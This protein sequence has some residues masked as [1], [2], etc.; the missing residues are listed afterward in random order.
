MKEDSLEKSASIRNL[1]SNG[2]KKWKVEKALKSLEDGKVTFFK[3]AEIAGMTVWDFADT[4]K[5]IATIINAI[6]L[7][8]KSRKLKLL[9][10]Y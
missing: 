1:L 10:G 6:S 3:A 4:N 7:L 5:Y 8:G 2:L 9:T